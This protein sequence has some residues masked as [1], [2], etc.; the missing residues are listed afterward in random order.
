MNPNWTASDASPPADERPFQPTGA[1]TRGPAPDRP[2]MGRALV[3]AG[4]LGGVAIVAVAVA[5]IG[6]PRHTASSGAAMDASTMP[7]TAAGPHDPVPYP[8]STTPAPGGTATAG[9]TAPAAQ[10]APGATAATTRPSVAPRPVHHRPATAARTTVAKAEPAPAHEV[11]LTCGVVVSVKAVTVQGQETG[12]GAV[13]GGAVGALV[14]SQVAGRGNHTVG[15][16]LGA[17][18]GALIG[19]QVEKH[20]RQATAWDV[21]LRMDDGTERTL[22]QSRAWRVGERVDVNGQTLRAL[23]P[24]G[25]TAAPAA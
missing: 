18:G 25:G 5:L 24:A 17:I 19:H 13:G 12:V 6:A 22:R 3:V 20:A 7:A 21:R 2:A 8:G 15:G 14:G 9:A 4:A 23:P 1:P 11:C 16:L 10:A